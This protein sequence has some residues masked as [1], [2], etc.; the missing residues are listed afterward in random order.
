M[1]SSTSRKSITPSSTDTVTN[2]VTE[3]AFSQKI[4]VP[5][6]TLKALSMVRFGGAVISTSTN[7]TDTLTVKA[8][9]GTAADNTGHLIYD[10][11]ALDV[12][13]NDACAFEGWCQVKTAGGA[14][15]GILTAFAVGAPKSAG[16]LKGTTLDAV[17][18]Q[19][20]TIADMYL[21]VT[22]TWSVASASNICRLDALWAEI[23]NFAN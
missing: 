15:T 9:L 18:A 17:E 10:S 7:S 6:Y 3:T 19:F 1:A 14:S 22:A 16:T 13:N 20:S 12:A 23:L 5:A 11:G 4:T 2:T 8:Y 21:V